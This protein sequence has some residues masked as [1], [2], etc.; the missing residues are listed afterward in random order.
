MGSKPLKMYPTWEPSEHGEKTK[1]TAKY[2]KVS[3]PPL[4]SVISSMPLPH[5]LQLKPTISKKRT[6]SVKL[7]E[8]EPPKKKTHPDIEVRIT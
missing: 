2:D 8:Q 7:A 6:L 1:I 4:S 3:S 5:P